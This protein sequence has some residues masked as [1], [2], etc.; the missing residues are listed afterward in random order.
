MDTK[1][2]SIIEDSIGIYRKYGIKS[3]SMEDL[4][5]ELK[6]SKKTIYKYVKNKDE[7]LAHIFLN[8]LNQEFDSRLEQIKKIGG[9]AIDFII[10]I[11]DHYFFENNA[12]TTAMVNDIY[13][14]YPLIFRQ[15]SAIAIQRKQ[16][17]IEYNI[18][19]GQQEGLYKLNLKKPIISLL[20]SN[21]D[22]FKK[23]PEQ[24]DFSEEDVFKE[25]IRLY[26][27]AIAN[28]HGI[29]YYEKTITQKC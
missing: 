12:I 5:K 4:C 29:E 26:I 22:I 2:L 9:N 21:I 14:H 8:F 7:L 15:F 11:T 6:I 28:P 25:I 24:S 16:E 20:F 23:L 18:A 19:Q 17:I 27:Y 1:F 3:V 13:T 10:R